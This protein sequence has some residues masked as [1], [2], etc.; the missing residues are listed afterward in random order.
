VP[1]HKNF[2]GDS[3][4]QVFVQKGISEESHVNK[5]RIPTGEEMTSKLVF[6]FEIICERMFVCENGVRNR[7]FI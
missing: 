5:M 7:I 6:S 1:L 4:L 3:F 2:C